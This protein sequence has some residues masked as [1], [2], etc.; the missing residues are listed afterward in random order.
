MPI[1][2]GR[3]NER[4]MIKQDIIDAVV[5]RTRLSEV[6]AKAMVEAAVE[7]VKEAL[8]NGEEVAL[9][10]FGTFKVKIRAPKSVRDMNTGEQYTIPS[11][12]RVVFE[13]GK[14]L[15]EI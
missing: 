11:K 4:F 13:P 1:G 15:K 12:R 6:D 5:T 7:A 10:G 9:R 14:D 2:F 8:Q 3:K